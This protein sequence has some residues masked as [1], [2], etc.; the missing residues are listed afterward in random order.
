[1]ITQASR[2]ITPFRTTASKCCRSNHSTVINSPL[3]YKIRTNICPLT[4]TTKYNQSTCIMMAIHNHNNRYF[5]SNV[6]KQQQESLSSSKNATVDNNAN[7]SQDLLITESCGRRITEVNEKKGDPGRMLRVIVE[8]GGC[9]GYQVEFTFSKEIEPGDQVFY[10]PSYPNAKV[11]ADEITMSFIKGSTIDF[12]ESMAKT[13]FVLE[14]NPNAE[15]GCSC[16][17]SFSVKAK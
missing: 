6:L 5:S 15:T 7:N 3:S 2:F 9:S 8:S 1:M 10:H 12:V 13:A 4:T 16:G 17:T 14:K 11:L